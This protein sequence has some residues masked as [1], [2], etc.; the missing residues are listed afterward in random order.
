MFINRSYEPELMDNFSITDSRVDQALIE[1]KIINKYLGGNNASQIGIKELLKKTPRSSCLKILDAGCGASDIVLPIQ[2]FCSQLKIFG[3]DINLRTCS[4]AKN[5]SPILNI[6]CGNILKVPF[7][8][9]SF[10][11][12]HASLFFHHFKEKEIKYII[13]ELMDAVNYGIII[14]DLRRSVIAYLGIKVLTFLFSQSKFVRND[15][16]LSVKRGFAKN[17]L[18]K[19]LKELG[20]KSYRIKRMHLFRWLIIIYKYET[21]RI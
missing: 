10:D 11:M 5:H 1:L 14:N 8:N 7:K 12:A 4:Y 13:K 20:I 15:A 3:L 2:K 19:I 17:E 18:L 9:N 6:T 21:N 16:P